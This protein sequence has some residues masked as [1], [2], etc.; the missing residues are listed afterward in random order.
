MRASV[1]WAP[2]VV[3]CA[4]CASLVLA[5]KQ[6]QVVR[7]ATI[8][9][10]HGTRTAAASKRSDPRS[11]LRLID[12]HVH[13]TPLDTT[14][15]LALRI[16]DAVGV[17]KFALKSAGTPGSPRYRATLRFAQHYGE[18]M[19]FFTNLDWSGID[20]PDWAER[21]VER[22]ELAM[23]DGAS[24]IKIFKALGLG[25]RLEDGSLLE[26][27]DPRLD[28]IFARAG[29]LGAIVAWHV[30]DPVA[31]FEP[32]TPQNERYAELSVAPDWS[33]HGG[34]YPSH[35]ALLAA[36]DRVVEK[37]AKTTFLGIHLANYPENLDYVD[38]LLDSCP[39][40]YVDISARLPEIGRHP[41]K[42]LRRFFLKHQE[43][44]LFGT[45]L[46]VSPNGLQLGSVSPKPP[47]FR[48][49]V[50]F[51]QIHRRFFET[52]DRQFEHP[53]PIQGD[54]KINGIDL[55][56]K[57]LVKIYRENAQ[58]LIFDARR[59]YLQRNRRSTGAQ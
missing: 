48:D 56:L 18:S 30:A 37:H 28:P 45:D 11:E 23:R 20:R 26:V 59:A 51:Y 1:R 10:A 24:G 52:A 21:E 25:V 35:D 57:V 46:I 44:V 9:A 2:W 17:D 19:A 49:A 40:L 27:D 6:R 41:L 53:T 32:V 50:K 16:F 22:L 8:D 34:D 14:F 29:E 5:C 54:W 31:F 38:R 33:F 3:S 36:R 42:K 58:R 7:K 39:N 12:S 43:R 55:P 15:N 4:L 47:E 13:I